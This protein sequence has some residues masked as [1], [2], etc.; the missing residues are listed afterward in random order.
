VANYNETIPLHQRTHAGRGIG[1]GTLSSY[2]AGLARAY[3]GLNKTPEA[4]DAAGGAVVSWGPRVGQRAQALETLKQVLR[5]APDLDAYVAYLDAR[6][7]E[8]SRDNPI[9]R[10]A[11]GQ[12]YISKAKYAQAIVQLQQAA[13]LQPN[14]AEI[15]QALV[16]SYDRQNDPEGAIRELLQSLQ[17]ARRNLNRYK[18][19]GQRLEK[20]DRHDESERAYTSIVEVLPNEAESHALLAEIRQEQGRWAEA[21]VHWEQVA[22]LRELEPTGLLK[23]AAAQVHLQQWDKAAETLAQVKVKTWPPRFADVANQVRVLEQQ[24][25]KGRQ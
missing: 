23:L 11:I 24:I 5:D 19:L 3:A 15:Y 1:D 7:A 4:V 14:D 2:Y 12:V 9:V 13:E 8:T 18:D 21:A 6:T 17:L 20:L 25:E 16:D 22:R 10:K